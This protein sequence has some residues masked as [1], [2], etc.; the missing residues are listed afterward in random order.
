MQNSEF[1]CL[2]CCGAAASA[3]A[4]AFHHRQCR[5][6]C[7]CRGCCHCRVTCVGVALHASHFQ[8]SSAHVC[9]ACFCVVLLL[10]LL[11]AAA[12]VSVSAHLRHCG[13]ALDD[14]CIPRWCRSIVV[15]YFYYLAGIF[16]LLHRCCP[17]N[18]RNPPSSSLPLLEQLLSV[19]GVSGLQC[20]SYICLGC[21]LPPSALSSS[22]SASIA[23]LLS[24]SPAWS[25]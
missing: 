3:C 1:F 20:C 9:C 2:A 13:F 12:C 7:Q 23:L 18:P 8:H 24:Q 4:A 10:L 17:G 16:V 14:C 22:T 6:Q 25:L 21:C 19:V 11:P 5:R 15:I